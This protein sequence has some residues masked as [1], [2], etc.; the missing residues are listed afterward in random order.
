M[1]TLKN[2]DVYI[3]NLKKTTKKCPRKTMKNCFQPKSKSDQTIKICDK[4]V[5]KTPKKESENDTIY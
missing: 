3:D 4:Y 2:F 5:Y 1:K